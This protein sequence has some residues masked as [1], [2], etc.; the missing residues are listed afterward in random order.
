MIEI[1]ARDD[2]NDRSQN[3]RRVQPPAEPNFKNSEL[4][5][6]ARKIF[7]RHRGHAFKIRRMRAKLARREQFLVQSLNPRKRLRRTHRR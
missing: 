3:I 7:E 4:N 1:H 5:P 2:R 6:R